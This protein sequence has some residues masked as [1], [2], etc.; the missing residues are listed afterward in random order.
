MTTLFASGRG[1][2]GAGA[3]GGAL[4]D[5]VLPPFE[6]SVPRFVRPQREAAVK[7]FLVQNVSAKP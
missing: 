5:T 4:N 7:A 6:A 1:F 2:F 3:G